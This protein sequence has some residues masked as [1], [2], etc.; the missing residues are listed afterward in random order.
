MKLLQSESNRLFIKRHFLIFLS[1]LITAD[2]FFTY[3]SVT[4]L[5]PLSAQS[6]RV[7]KSY[8]E[9]YEGEVTSAKISE[10]DEMVLR[11]EEVFSS[12]EEVDEKHKSGLI[13]DSEYEEFIGEYNS[14]LSETEGFNRFL[15]IYYDSLSRNTDIVDCA[16]WGVLLSGDSVDIFIVL[17]II[18]S[19]ILLCVNDRESGI[20]YIKSTTISGRKKLYFTQLFILFSVSIFIAVCVPIFKYITA[21]AFYGLPCPQA[22]VRCVED[23]VIGRNIP[24]VSAYFTEC[25]FK[26]AGT[27][28]LTALAYFIGII[29]NSSLYT[30]FF[31]FVITYIPAY[32][33]RDRFIL[34]LLPFPTGMLEGYSLYR[35]WN[36][37]DELGTYFEMDITKTII[38]LSV[39]VIVSLLAVIFADRHRKR[40]VVI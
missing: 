30:A 29:L 4:K 16:A 37:N 14:V 12:K 11:R 35:S 15:N 32:L 10:I 17:A 2:L 34:Y 9:K 38:Y 26:L 36:I 6:F 18:L 24:L 22:S 8:M 21:D 20:D 19:V 40:R 39:I 13:S 25:L 5:N 27:V 33:F 3:T 1:L 31:T 28:Y 7:F 23:Y